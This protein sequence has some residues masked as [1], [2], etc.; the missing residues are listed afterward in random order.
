MAMDYEEVERM[1]Q[2]NKQMRLELQRLRNIAM[3]EINGSKYN[4][5]STNHNTI[6][7]TSPKSFDDQMRLNKQ[8]DNDIE[9]N[10]TI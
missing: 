5:Q 8:R 10:D 2:E 7:E 6:E 1:K 9:N 3:S 4:G